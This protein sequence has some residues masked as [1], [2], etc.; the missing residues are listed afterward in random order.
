MVGGLDIERHN[1]AHPS[2][3]ED[4]IRYPT[5]LLDSLQ[6]A[7][8]KEDGT[9]TIVGIIFTILILLHQT[10]AEVVVVVDEVDLY[11]G[12]LDG[13]YLDDQRVVRIIDDKIHT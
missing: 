12:R 3:T 13:G 8:G 1:T 4:D 10:L 6:Y 9:L 11:P 5:E 7:T 2:L